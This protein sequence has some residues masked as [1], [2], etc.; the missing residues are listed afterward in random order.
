MDDPDLETA[1]HMMHRRFGAQLTA[2]TL[3][4]RGVL[5]WDGKRFHHAS[6]YWVPVADTTG[7]GDIFHAGLFMECCRIGRCS[8]SSTSPARRLH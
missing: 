2:A 7:A 6:A 3:G 4:E 5:A 8:G 1:L